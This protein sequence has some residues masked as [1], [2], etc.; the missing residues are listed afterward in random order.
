MKSY[1]FTLEYSHDGKA[2]R[3][4]I[5]VSRR[6]YSDNSTT[7]GDITDWIGA[8]R[9]A[10]A[11]ATRATKR[12]E[13]ITMELCVAT[14]DRWDEGNTPTRQTGFHRW[15]T[16]EPQDEFGVHLM[17]DIRYTPEHWD[18]YLTPKTLLDDIKNI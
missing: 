3:R 12:G 10:V 2:G 6:L 16:Q 8:L 7:M 5:K 1:E 14:Y 4:E 17:P 18:L 9:K 15:I 11:E 13:A